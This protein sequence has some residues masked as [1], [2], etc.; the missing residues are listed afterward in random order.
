MASNMGKFY[1]KM[2]CYGIWY[3]VRAYKELSV[4]YN[5]VDSYLFGTTKYILLAIFSIIAYHT[6]LLM[7]F[8]VKWLA[9]GLYALYSFIHAK[10]SG[11][12]VSSVANTASEIVTATSELNAAAA[13]TAATA[14]AGAANAAKLAGAGHAFEA[15][16]ADAEF[17]F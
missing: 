10:F 9:F 14:A 4:Y 11:E 1:L 7:V 17:E 12:V 3:L 5:V 8:I 13:A 15:K 16:G 2:I 6:I